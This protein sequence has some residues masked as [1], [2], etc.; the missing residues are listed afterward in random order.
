MNDKTIQ[1]YHVFSVTSSAVQ[2]LEQRF[3]EALGLLSID[4]EGK[5]VQEITL[6]GMW[7]GSPRF[8]LLH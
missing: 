7:A 1:G 4:T 2:D 3:S 8:S 6:R 5:L